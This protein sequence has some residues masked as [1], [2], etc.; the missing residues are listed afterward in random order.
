MIHL[1]FLYQSQMIYMK[2]S[3]PRSLV[4]R[5]RVCDYCRANQS[6]PTNDAS[7][8]IMHNFGILSCKEHGHLA[9]RDCNAYL[10][11]IGRIRMVD[12]EH[13]PEI[14]RFLDILRAQ[15]NGFPVV[16]SCGDI[17][18]G[19]MLAGWS[20][21][22][23]DHITKTSTGEWSLI[24]KTTDEKRNLL[25]G[26]YISEY[27][28]SD[29][30]CHF[31]EGFAQTIENALTAL[32]SGIIYSDEMREWNELSQDPDNGYAPDAPYIQKVVDA[33]GNMFC[34][35]PIAEVNYS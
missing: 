28:R 14:K 23:P 33:S 9:R 13:V 2:C 5:E 11:R 16:R 3:V 18:H 10:G 29:M 22:T 27:L 1:T 12:A 30:I 34:V 19:W 15:E 6:L 25:K 7:V 4:M 24:V 32:N 21:D 17:D 35:T 8:S 20:L 31:P 26:I